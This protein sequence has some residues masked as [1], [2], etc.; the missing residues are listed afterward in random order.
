MP[1]DN[2]GTDGQGNTGTDGTDGGGGTGSD[3]NQFAGSLPENLRANEHLTSFQDA[4]A[5]AQA[6]LD[7]RQ[8]VPVV[9]ENAEGYEIPKTP[10]EGVDLPDEGI[11]AYRT[12][13]HQLGLTQDQAAKLAQIDQQRLF[14][15]RKKHQETREAKVKEVEGQLKQAWGEEFEA[16][17][18]RA[19][20]VIDKFGGKDF[21]GFL[22]QTGLNNHPLLIKFLDAVGGQFSEDQLHEGKPKPE[23]KKRPTSDDGRPRLRFSSMGDK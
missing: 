13:S 21:S 14:D 8:R 15:M 11:N 16:R 17:A 9:P 3:G 10:I 12:V 4:G 1:E 18:S 19:G 22:K 20:L 23:D 2:V 5:L 7:T 6:Y